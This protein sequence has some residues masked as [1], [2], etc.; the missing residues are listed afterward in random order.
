MTTCLREGTAMALVRLKRSAQ[1][2]LPA[3]LRQQ[4][5]LNL[6]RFVGV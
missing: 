2:T 5:P 4:F 1:I 6:S 3:E